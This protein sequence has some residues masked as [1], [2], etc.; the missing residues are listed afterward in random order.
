MLD[1]H[2][3]CTFFAYR[4]AYICSASI[5]SRA[6]S[7]GVADLDE[8]GL[9]ESVVSRFR[10]AGFDVYRNVVLD[11]VEFDVVAFESSSDRVYVHVVEVKR[12]PRDKVYKQIWRRIELADYLYVAIPY[13]FYTWALSRVDPRVGILLI[14]NGDVI[15]FR[16]PVYLGKGMA[17]VRSMCRS[18]IV[19]SEL[20]KGVCNRFA[21]PSQ[22]IQSTA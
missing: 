8:N 17:I 5:R 10:S 6:L 2:R 21:E 18:A 3:T 1:F 15:V 19:A 12:R 9:V 14:R 13:S 20:L 22:H 11:G 16:R 4:C 7:F